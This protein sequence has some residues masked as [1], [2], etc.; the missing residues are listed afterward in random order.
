[1]AQQPPTQVAPPRVPAGRP[2]VRIAGG[3]PEGHPGRRR[4]PPTA[5]R[6]L[7]QFVVSNLAAVALLLA[8]TVWASGR[9]AEKESLADARAAADALASV[10]VEPA[11]TDEILTGDPGTLA[12][13][14]A[15]AAGMRRDAEL[16][17]IKIWAGDGT[18]VY[19]DEPRLVG[20]AYPLGPDEQEALRSG[21]T[22]AEVSDL[23]KPENR[24]ERARGWQLLEVYR[25]VH[26]PSGEPLLFETYFRY[27]DATARQVDIWLTFAPISVTALLLLL[28]LQLPL[29]HRMIRQL[30]A[31]EQERQAL[32]TRTA[33]ASIDERRRIAGSLHDGIVQDLSAASYVL[34]G[35]VQGLE[36][37]APEGTGEITASLRAARTAVRDSVTALRSLLIEIYPAH[38]SE[39]GL[40]SALRDLATRLRPRGVDVVVR[41][42]TDVDVPPDVAALVFRVAQEALINVAKHAGARRVTLEVRTEVD[43]VTLEVTDD[44]VGFDPDVSTADTR[45][46][47]FGLRV[48][49]DLAD[50]A[51]AT[52]DVATAPGEGTALRLRVPLP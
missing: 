31:G 49:A 20:T 13:L 51:G 10:V 23:E 50:A 36:N 35:A 32:Q 40:P 7:T 44:G 46:G 12:V 15:V 5:A 17:R 9:A 30:R 52:L 25:R 34:S 28:L 26:T 21:D 3:F 37:R 29:G 38:L 1:M 6:V 24:Y 43:A 42:P 47:H 45:S 11:L 16:V 8:G 19:S 33:D 2:W 18:I 41:V 4:R 27:G 39:A 48:V 14:D 22:Y